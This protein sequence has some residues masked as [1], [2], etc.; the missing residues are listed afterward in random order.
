M[1]APFAAIEAATAASGVAAISNATATI[2]ALL[3]PVIFDAAY[4]AEFGI[5]GSSPVASGTTEDLE[6][7]AAGDAITI[8]AT[9]YT[10]TA[11]EPDGTGMTLL[12]LQEV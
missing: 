7:V 3:I 1:T 5:A 10:V 4:A 2:G 8:G 11:V 12:R 9:G 6:S